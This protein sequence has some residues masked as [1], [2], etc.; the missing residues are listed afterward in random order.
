MSASP[1]RS[2]GFCTQELLTLGGEDFLEWYLLLFLP[3]WSLA[4]WCFHSQCSAW[5]RNPQLLDCQHQWLEF[6]C[7]PLPLG[8]S[9]TPFCMKMM[10]DRQCQHWH[11]AMHLFHHPFEC[12][13]LKRKEKLNVRCAGCTWYR[14]LCGLLIS[15]NF[16]S[17]STQVKEHVKI[18]DTATFESYRPNTR[19]CQTFEKI[20]IRNNVW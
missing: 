5:W 8:H 1:S 18:T 4:H 17:S 12:E 10:D 9:Q 13:H 6:Y 20:I 19:L 15:I 14:P 2:L 11:R 7:P 3:P 16:I